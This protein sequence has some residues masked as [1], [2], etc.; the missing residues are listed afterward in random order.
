MR[1]ALIT[2]GPLDIRGDNPGSGIRTIVP[3]RPGSAVAN[4]LVSALADGARV[5]VCDLTTGA[6]SVSEAA[7]MFG[8]VV[9]YLAD[10][11]GAGVVVVCPADAE[12]REGL[13]GLPMPAT[14]LL[15]ESAD[16]GIARLSQL[17]PQVH[18][19]E[20][21]LA[22]HLTSPRAS[23]LFI[24][25]AL[26]GWQLT[27]LVASVALVVCELVTNSIVHATSSV[28]VRLSLA[29]ERVL[30]TV[31]DYG[32]GHPTARSDDPQD[33]LLGGRGLLVVEESTLGWGVLAATPSGKTVWAVF[34]A[35][36]GA[37]EQLPA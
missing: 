11:P 7:E 36:L 22:A 27:P 24:T 35:T 25:R 21:H 1:G 4:D 15:S 34:D 9:R 6:V 3:G 2:V 8:P 14:L 13:H 30:L 12:A 18:R 29:D 16:A 37:T 26:R 19:A 28:H 33:H 5:V 17:L 10:W 20:V 32:D 23:R 31:R